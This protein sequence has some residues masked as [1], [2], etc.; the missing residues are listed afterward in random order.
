M[1]TKRR[2]ELEEE[3]MTEAN[4]AR[5]IGL[6][7]PTEEGAKPITKKDAC[8]LLGMAYNTKR[9]DQIIAE[10]NAKKELDKKRRAE[11]RGKQ[12]TP[13]EVTYAIGEYIGGETI[14]AISKALYRSA[15]FVRGIL[16]KH[17]VPIR[18]TSHDYFTPALIPDGAVR[19][20]FK[21][22]EVVYSARYDSL[23][24]IEAEIENSP[25]HGWVYR[26]WLCAEKWREYC[27]QP[28]SELASLEHL[29]E[30]GVRV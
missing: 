27:Y 19:E 26:C 17:N 1:A 20:R 23:A 16:D 30:L 14:D 13:E 9:L 11:R 12:A 3:K 2:T 25:K 24:L 6:L 4:I 10:F 8:S 15:A 29:R 22:G 18:A 28:A 7:F 21:E 5:V